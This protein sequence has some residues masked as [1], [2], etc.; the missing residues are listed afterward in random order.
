MCLLLCHNTLYV[1]VCCPTYS[2]VRGPEWNLK[3]GPGGGKLSG[4]FPL[5]PTSVMLAVLVFVKKNIAFKKRLNATLHL[6][7]AT[8]CVILE[9]CRIEIQRM[10]WKSVTLITFLKLATLTLSSQ[11]NALVA[12]VTHIKKAAHFPNPEISLWALLWAAV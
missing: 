3:S 1:P 9:R 11:I 4:D 6:H 12:M 10:K 5:L 2:I 7:P 8:T